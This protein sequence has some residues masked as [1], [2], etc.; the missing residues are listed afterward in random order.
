MLSLKVTIYQKKTHTDQYLRPPTRTQARSGL[1]PAALH[2]HGIHG[3]EGQRLGD[4]ALE[5]S[6]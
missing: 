1:N 5:Q 3:G 4:R 2:P 6:S